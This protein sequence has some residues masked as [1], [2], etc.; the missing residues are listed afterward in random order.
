MSV[1]ATNA[2]LSAADPAY[3]ASMPFETAL[4][5]PKAEV[6]RVGVP[7]AL[8]VGT[9]RPERIDEYLGAFKLDVSAPPPVEPTR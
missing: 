7:T 3:W 8:I 9:T 5:T 1:S 6:E 2:A 4:S